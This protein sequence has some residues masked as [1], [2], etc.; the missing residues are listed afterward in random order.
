MRA[1]V[2]AWVFSAAAASLRASPESA[3]LAREGSEHIY[4]LEYDQSI[5]AYRRAVAADPQD[6]G[7]H[8]G[9]ASA[10]WL[11]L[12]YRRG[13]MTVDDYMGGLTRRNATPAPPPPPETAAQFRE[14]LDQAMTMARRRIA[15]NPRDAEAHYQLGAAVGLRASYVATVEGSSRG[16]FSAAREA[17]NEHE[18]VIELDSRRKDAGLITGTYRYIVAALSLPLRWVAYAAGFGGGKERG[19][20]LIEDAAGYDGDNQTDARL[21][22]ILLYNREKRYDDA[23]QQLETLKNK[24]PRNRLIWLE[25]GSTSLRAGRP[26]DAERFLS[27]GLSRFAGDS[28]ARMFGENALWHYKR[29]VARAWLGR[30]VEAEADLTAAIATDG[31]KWVH[32]R[33]P[34]ELGKLA[35]KGGRPAAARPHFVSA[36]ALSGGDNDLATATEARELL[37]R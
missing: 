33:A 20:R 1:A 36:A 31:R 19:V 32:G 29:G 6:A 15:A 22:L 9:L 23:L 2:A 4:N 7:A 17:Y 35:V 16:A 30:A 25:S 27:D 11:S 18:V 10:I 34:L 14:A 5:A 12:T 24:Y 37:K 3:A 26:A 28:R 8:R 13:N 21:A